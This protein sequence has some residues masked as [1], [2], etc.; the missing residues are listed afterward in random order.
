MDKAQ[1]S[2]SVR[3][4]DW[5]CGRCQRGH[6]RQNDK[7]WTEQ[8]TA[9]TVKGR[10]GPDWDH[11]WDE[12]RFAG[13]L[14][15]DNPDCHDVVSAGGVVTRD[16]WQ[17]SADEWETIPSYHIS[18]LNPPPSPFR[19]D[20][21]VPESVATRLTEAAGLLWADNDAAANK[22]RQAVECVL[23]ERAV[24]K[25]PREGPR[26]AIPLHQRIVSFAKIAPEAGGPLLAIKWIGN[27]G[28]HKG[29]LTRDDVLDAFE[30]MEV[31][32]EEIYVGH[33]RAILKKVDAINSRK[34]PLGRA[35]ATR[36]TF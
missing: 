33:R 11:E 9:E 31:V 16:Y 27:S 20:P 21:A 4:F 6:L 26:K 10:L 29:G 23:D 3:S 35:R 24:K 15:C 5:L 13:L 7:A 36:A 18:S 34:K 2:K 12:Y 32:L 22:I 14:R 17:V 19:I 30:I 1:W 8:A 28:S 25:F